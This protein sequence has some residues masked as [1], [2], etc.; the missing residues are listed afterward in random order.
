MNNVLVWVFVPS[1]LLALRARARVRVC[2]FGGGGGGGYVEEQREV[3]D[4]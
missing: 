4:V 2:V 3:E 1:L